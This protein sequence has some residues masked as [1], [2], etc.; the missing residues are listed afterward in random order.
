MFV[1]ESFFKMNPFTDFVNS[2]MANM[3]SWPMFNNSQSNGHNH[4]QHNDWMSHF[5][6]FNHND[7]TKQSSEMIK[8]WMEKMP[9][10]DVK[11]HFKHMQFEDMNQ[12]LMSNVKM[13][14]QISKDLAENASSM[15]KKKSEMVQEHASDMF[16]HMEKMGSSYNTE[17]NLALY[18]EFVKKSF[19]KMMGEFKELGN[20]ASK[21]GSQSYEMANKAMHETMH[22]V[23]KKMGC[24]ESH[25]HNSS[26]SVMKKKKKK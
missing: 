12:L 14:S 26:C 19:A 22:N 2:S 21:Y 24:K 23:E 3:K 20:M 8:N 6:N 10:L 1:N 5:S 25:K 18:A 15:M 16:K 11:E 9:K 17:E 4:H 13:V 7:Y